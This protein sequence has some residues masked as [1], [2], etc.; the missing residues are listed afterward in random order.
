MFNQI[1]IR[2]GM[3]KGFIPD[4]GIAFFHTLQRLS[5][6]QFPRRCDFQSVIIH[7]NL[8]C[9][10]IQIAAMHHRVDNQL[11]N[12]IRRDFINIL[13]VNADK[14]SSQMNISQNKLKCFLYLFPQR[15]RIFPSINKNRFRCSL[16][17]TALNGN[18]KPSTAR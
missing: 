6:R 2:K 7:R 10:M 16:K 11:T 15:T 12:C 3:C 4:F 8:Y 1:H 17:H 13:T 18:M 9:T 14:R 5:H